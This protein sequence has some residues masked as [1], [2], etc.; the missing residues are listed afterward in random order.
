MTEPI[1]QDILLSPADDQIWEVFH[2]N[3]KITEYSQAPSN[4]EVRAYMKELHETLPFDGYPMVELPLPLKPLAVSLDAA[5]EGRRSVRKLVPKP[6]DLS[7]LA[8][9]FHYGYGINRENKGTLFPRSFRVVPSGGA[10]YPLELFFYAA[11]VEGL[12]AGLYHY[13][14]L[15]NCLRFLRDGISAKRISE[16]VIQ[17]E[18]A[19]GASLIIFI[20]AV[21]ERSIFKYR[22]R[23]YRFILIEAGHVAQNL[24]L[25]SHALGLASVNIGGFLDR[26]V[27]SFL[28]LD[29]ITHSTIYMMAM[30]DRA[31]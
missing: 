2:E 20:T 15:N 30:G 19:V 12:E 3:S 14:P 28:A 8:T 9:L 6:I 13:N 16:I 10:L 29:G 26:Q 11:L 24:N 17:P 21:F 18:I 4:E 23:G 22:D 25:V 27:D 31:R 5:I 1:W 7:Q